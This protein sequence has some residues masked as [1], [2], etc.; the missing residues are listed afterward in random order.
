MD[1]T[2][3]FRRNLA[4]RL[5][6]AS[7]LALPTAAMAWTACIPLG[8]TP[9]STEC[10]APFEITDDSG[11]TEFDGG[12]SCPSMDQANAD[13]GIGAPYTGCGRALSEPTF[14]AGACCYLTQTCDG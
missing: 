13:R 3:S 10:F 12:A 14:N 1:R 8:G 6:G 7:A 2:L 4:A 9:E 5:I 11:A